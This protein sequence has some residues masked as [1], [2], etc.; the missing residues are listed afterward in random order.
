M[1]PANRARRR[2]RTGRNGLG[3]ESADRFAAEAL[4]HLEQLYPA[5]LRLAGDP[6]GAQELVTETY[7]RAYA[8][9]GHRGREGIT[10]WLYRNMASAAEE[11]GLARGGDLDSEVP[12]RHR[13]AP[14]PGALPGGGVPRGDVPRGDVPGGD[15][16]AALQRV[17]VRRRLAIYLAD[18]EGFSAAKIARIL[19]V[20]ASMVRFRLR[21]GRR[22]LRA[23]LEARA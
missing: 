10:D 3:G 19:Q 9:L 18:V 13:V 6:A 23:A 17:P 11:T 14:R 20:P 4:P 22:Q 16:K 2:G 1:Q 21:R 12:E 5:A 7:A 15:V 8:T